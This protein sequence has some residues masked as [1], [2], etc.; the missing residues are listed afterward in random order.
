MVKDKQ[1]S[2]F[3]L[4]EASVTM[5]IVAVFVA[6]C[7]N[8]FTKRHITYQESDGHGRYE[9]Y[10]NSSGIVQRYVENN[11]PRNV[12]GTTCVF[13]PPRYAKYLLINASGGGSASGAGTFI[14]TFYTSIDAP[15]TITPGAAGGATTIS[16]GG[17]TIV[18]AAGGGGEMVEISTAASNVK[19]CTFQSTLF[20]GCGTT[21]NCTQ[22]G[23]NLSVTFCRSNDAGDSKNLQIPIADV[24]KYKQS[25]SGS[26]LVYA[27][28]SDYVGHNI[29]AED[30]VKMATS[31]TFNSY[32]TVNVEF[33]TTNSTESQMENYLSALGIEDG[34]AAARPGAPGQ[35][36]GVVILW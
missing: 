11:S 25:Y 17:T 4:L 30:A 21:A 9:C 8:A 36:G 20:N 23:S 19:S 12:A 10:R 33:E 14:S 35:P 3:S 6:L 2:G 13:R 31:G 26:S 7:S 29:A 32:F 34:I 16:K 18:S 28:I 15:L 5:L 1:F 27:D 24:K 22:A